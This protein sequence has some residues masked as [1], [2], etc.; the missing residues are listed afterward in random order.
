[1]AN[2]KK[3]SERKDKKLDDLSKIKKVLEKQAKE[4]YKTIETQKT[5]V[6]EK[7]I[8]VIELTRWKT[9]HITIVEQKDNEIGKLKK[10][11]KE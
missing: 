8:Q 4:M 3:M 2:E 7:E 6:A 1:M 11:L 10:D 5:V 9:E